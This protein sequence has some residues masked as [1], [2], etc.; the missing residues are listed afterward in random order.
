MPGA[1]VRQALDGE[2]CYTETEAGNPRNGAGRGNAFLA[3]VPVCRS[4]WM[5]SSAS[6]PIGP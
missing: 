4:V 1:F 2:G 3:V 5:W 6:P